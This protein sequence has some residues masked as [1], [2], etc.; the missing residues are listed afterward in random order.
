MSKTLNL[1]TW[2]T[3]KVRHQLNTEYRTGTNNLLYTDASYLVESKSFGLGAH[4]RAKNGER[5]SFYSGGISENNQDFERFYFE[6][7]A[8]SLGLKLCLQ[9]K[10]KNPVV[11]IDSKITYN[12]Y[13]KVINT[14]KDQPISADLISNNIP[15]T[16]I[17]RV[18]RLWSEIR[19]LYYQLR[20]PRLL[21]IPSHTDI[22]GNEEADKMAKRGRVEA[23]QKKIVA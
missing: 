9:K 14:A 5:L 12:R 19:E 1:Q 16:H 23:N 3:D 6:D 15:Y 22:Y 7:I 10:I 4:I 2:D 18:E 21:L 8:L 17:E 11:H 13:C 20:I